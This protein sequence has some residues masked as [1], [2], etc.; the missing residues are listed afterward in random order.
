VSTCSST[1]PGCGNRSVAS[2][3]AAHSGIDGVTG[4][5]EY[6]ALADNNVYTNLMAQQN[7][8]AAADAAERYPDRAHALAVAA[9]EPPGWRAAAA[10]IAIPVNAKL[11]VHEQAEG[12]TRNQVWDFAGTAKSKYPLM[13]H[14]PY[15]ELYRKQV[16]KQA[17]LVLAMLRRPD[18]F[19]LEQ[20]A[21]NF[22]YYERLTV[23]DSSLSAGVQAVLAAEVGSLELAYDY[24]AEAALIDLDDLEHNVRD[25]LHIAALASAWTAVVAGFGGLRH[26]DGTLHFSPRLPP[27]TLSGLIFTVSAGDQAI[28]VDIGTAA[29][30]YTL[31]A[32][33]PLRIGHHGETV[34]LTACQPVTLAI[35]AA[36]PD[37]RPTQPPRRAPVRRAAR[38]A[39]RTQAPR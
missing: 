16:V 30:T 28:R 9:D 4:P 20:K 10:A 14:Y 12:F 29:A 24:L 25:G 35:P 11:G 3:K 27:T 6:S 7:L 38:L 26:R 33:T 1:P 19:S 39:R 32:G 34:T 23:R 21:R 17:D 22:A 15:F 13:L 36:P 37:L 31:A 5:D 8:L 2:T 18:A